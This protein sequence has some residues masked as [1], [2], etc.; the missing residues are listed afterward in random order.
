MAAAAADPDE[1]AEKTL[2]VAKLMLAAEVMD[3]ED[4][5]WECDNSS[6]HALWDKSKFIVEIASFR[7]EE[8]E[9][10]LWRQ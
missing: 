8:V 10:T 7:G 9:S 3:K 1:E 4:D 5:R 2:I 6:Q